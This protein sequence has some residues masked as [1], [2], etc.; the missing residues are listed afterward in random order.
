MSRSCP[1][2]D[3]IDELAVQCLG[4]VY[5]FN[6]DADLTTVGG[7]V[8]EYPIDR[9]IYVCIIQYY[10]RIISAELQKDSL[11]V[12]GGSYASLT[13]S[14]KRRL[15]SGVYGEG[16]STTVQPAARAGASLDIAVPGESSMA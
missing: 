8:R 9:S 5:P 15:D 10:R 13:S 11:E 6:S 3:G 1:V 12:A 4:C 16:L 2:S 7:C 14:P